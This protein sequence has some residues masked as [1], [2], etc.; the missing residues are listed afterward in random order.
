MIC[1]EHG[2]DQV[3]DSVPTPPEAPPGPST[4]PRYLFRWPAAAS[5]SLVVAANV[6]VITGLRVPF[7]VPAI[8][9]WFLLINPVYLLC[10]VSAWRRLPVAE[11]IGYSV[12]AIL[13]LLMLAGLGASFFLPPLG[14]R[15]P[16]DPITIMLIGDVITIS[17][18]LVRCRFP[19]Q[20]S[21]GAEL[22]KVSREERR[23]VILAGLCVLLAVLGANRLNNSAGDQVSMAALA[24]MA[25]T[26]A[27]LL[28]WR[29]RIRD[30][31]TSVVIYL[32]SLALLLMTSLR[33]WYV[34][35]HDIQTEYRTFQLTMAHGGWSMSSFHSAYYACLSITILPTE[36]EQLVRVS[37]PYVYKGF[38]QLIFAVCPAL[39][40]TISRRY[41][42]PPVSILAATYFIGFPTF[43][44]DMPFLNR[45]EVAFIF[46][47]V[48]ILA[49]TNTAWP[50]P[51]RKIV[52]CIAA[53]GVELSHYS[54][55]YMFFGTLLIAWAAARLAAIRLRRRRRPDGTQADQPAS[56]TLA[57]TI[58]AGSIAV[59]AAIILGWGYLA[60]HTIGPVITTAES[61]I[62]GL[63]G[64]VHNARSADVSYSLLPGKALSPATVLRDYRTVT[65]GQRSASSLTTAAVNRYPT[66]VVSEPNL[67]VTQAGHLLGQIGLPPAQVNGLVRLIAA[68]GEQVFVIIGLIAF[69]AVGAYRARIGRELYF[70]AFGS[71]TMVGLITALPNLSVDYGV[72]RAFQE[73]L[74][75]LAPVLVT[76]SMVS[77]R[78]IGRS[79]A[80]PAAAVLCLI[81]FVSTSGLMPQALGGYPAQLNLN[82]S[83]SYY[84][85]FYEHPQEKSAV[86]WLAGQ[87]SVL[88][89]GVQAENFTEQY[90]FNAASEVDAQQQVTDFYPTLIQKSTWV[91][92][93]YTMVRTGR[94][95][96]YYDGDL[97]TYMYPVS[98][99]WDSKN[100]VY[101][102]GGAEIY[103]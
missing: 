34:T 61:V 57:R 28:L 97:I 89:S 55:M 66:R 64:H 68:K 102:N 69:A 7:L 16:L 79:R 62:P 2:S 8:E 37:G 101:S 18:A 72:L 85:Y 45:Q 84:D 76:G 36:I 59:T 5:A 58:G 91:L 96:A 32:L 17:L 23:L 53:A 70:L 43:F 60:T 99:L 100:L 51:W 46:A 22:R 19:A 30:A 52:F 31:L 54:T 27:L 39:V 20:L 87:R 56:I 92:L 95:T 14:V 44:T 11:L 98:L 48:A 4:A 82:N 25:G 86:Q 9:F 75:L 42:S 47:C 78:I 50:G 29:R 12:A 6:L 80:A 26:L 94:A 65:L 77:L 81:I 49:I 21:W 10:M 38:F 3:A 73:A 41:C 13:L 24:T 83:G 15:R 40:Y 93:G 33:G 103:K 88:P 71:I 63:P 35:G 67:P 74:I 1:D 90:Y